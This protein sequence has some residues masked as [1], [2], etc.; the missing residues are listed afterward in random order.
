VSAEEKEKGKGPTTEQK[1]R[2]IVT[3]LFTTYRAP[4]GRMYGSVHHRP[5]HALRH[6]VLSELMQK[7]SLTYMERH[8]SWP[9]KDARAA[10]ASF[11]EAVTHEVRPVPVRCHWDQQQLLLDVGDEADTVLILDGHGVRETSDAPV[12]FR[13]SPSS[14]PLPWPL[15]GHNGDLSLLW[16]LVRVVEADRPLV[17]ALLITAWLTGIPQPV[18]LV[19]GPADAG[20]T[21]TAR[22]L[23]SLVDPVTHQRGGSLPERE[24][25]WKARVAQSRV[26]FV[27]NSSHITAKTSDL[28]CRVATGGELTTR[29][30]YTNDGAHISDLLVPIWLTS[31]DSGVLRGDLQSRIVPIELGAIAEEDRAVL[32]DLETDQEQARPVITKALLDLT[33]QVI[34][35]L[36][37]V[38][39]SRL[40]HRM[41]DFNLV[42]RC[43]DTILGTTGETRLT[44]QSAEL[45]N[46]VL[47]ADP[48]AIALLH[49]V[50]GDT[51]NFHGA[52]VTAEKLRAGLTA[53]QLL[54]ALSDATPGDKRGTSWPTTPKVL[55]SRLKTIAPAMLQAKGVR[56]EFRRTK[57]ARL[58]AITQCD[59]DSA[60]SSAPEAGDARVTHAAPW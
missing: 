49:L 22:Y 11:L 39:R 23:L 38:D 40:I 55:S 48:V 14:A 6:G 51:S 8:G 46:D 54:A 44:G 10:V 16:K 36:P 45:A 21:T 4:D 35:M 50:D 30:L 53:E 60:C 52:K 37:T 7:I 41:T 43:V 26:V 27:D 57:A 42:L 58:I 1:L 3:E 24:D 56:I 32:S 47:E 28:M 12:A 5:G 2:K 9:N 34:A 19:T 29:Q 13:R 18:L 59:G 33:D 25:E 31:I 15:T 17:L 20:K